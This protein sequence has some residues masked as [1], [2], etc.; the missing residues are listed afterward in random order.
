MALA[1]LQRPRRGTSP[2]RRK[3]LLDVKFADR[4]H[5]RFSRDVFQAVQVGDVGQVLASE[6]Q[7]L[8][9]APQFL[10]GLEVVR[11]SR[12]FLP[13]CADRRLVNPDFIAA[14]EQVE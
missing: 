13:R 2:F 11:D 1:D 3:N 8:V 12:S 4:I 5:P 9:V 7:S 10:R 6:E 14:G